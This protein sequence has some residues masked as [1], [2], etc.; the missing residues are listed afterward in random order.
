MLFRMSSSLEEDASPLSAVVGLLSGFVVALRTGL[1]DL[2]ESTRSYLVDRVHAR[3]AS[4]GDPHVVLA[5]FLDPFFAPC[6][7][8]DVGAL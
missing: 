3:F 1:P 5:F 4:F 7:H 2:P 6:R 8:A